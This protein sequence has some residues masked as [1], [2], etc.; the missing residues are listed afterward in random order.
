MLLDRP[1]K[2]IAVHLNYR[3]RLAERGKE[4]AH[5]SYF[6]KAPTTLSEHGRDLVR[7][8]GCE[9]LQMEAEVALV[10]GER[11][12]RVLESEAWSCVAWVTAANDA[13]ITD[14]QYADPGSNVHSKSF[15]GL[16]PVGPRLIP[17]DGLDPDGF[18]L[19]G[20]VGDR[21]V[22]DADRDDLVFG[23]PYLVADLSRVMT[24]EPGDV[25]LTG[26]PR[27]ST[28]VEPGE[29]AS[30][31]VTHASGATSGRLANVVVAEPGDELPGPGAPPRHDD[32]T[33]AR[34][35][36]LPLDDAGS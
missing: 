8:A 4:V 5:P 6:L 14:L 1:G 16:T 32:A 34:A 18:R 30:V 25:I 29:T 21:L 17:A 9:L 35:V 19:R 7:P 36:R 22:Q 33:R 3:S 10:I 15:D 24:L 12:H 26:T 2:L 27:G 28:V 31:E 20:W 13:G 23:F 11:T